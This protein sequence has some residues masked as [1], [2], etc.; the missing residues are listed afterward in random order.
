MHTWIIHFLIID[1]HLKF[2]SIRNADVEIIILMRKIKIIT[3]Q[4]H[5]NIIFI[6]KSIRIITV[7]MVYVKTSLVLQQP[8]LQKKFND[9]YYLI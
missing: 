1:L 4:I 6:T 5:L 2:K 7:F 9:D 8:K 3:L